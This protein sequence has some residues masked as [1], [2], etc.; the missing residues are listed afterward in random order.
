MVGGKVELLRCAV[1]GQAVNLGEILPILILANVLRDLVRK[2][3][4]FLLQQ[5]RRAEE[6]GRAL[7]RKAPGRGLQGSENRHYSARDWM[8][9]TRTGLPLGFATTRGGCQ[10]FRS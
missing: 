1:A 5:P 10:P 9:M 7:H 4:Q 2:V 6:A 8:S 3:A